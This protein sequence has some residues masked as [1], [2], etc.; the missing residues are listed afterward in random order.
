MLKFISLYNRQITMYINISQ[1]RNITTRPNFQQQNSEIE[2]NI[3]I[4]NTKCDEFLLSKIDYNEIE[5]MKKDLEMQL[6]KISIDCEINRLKISNIF[7]KTIN[8]KNNYDSR[9]TFLL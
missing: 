2:N 6:N 9:Q 1:K 8:N 3:E 7:N 5:N 4:F